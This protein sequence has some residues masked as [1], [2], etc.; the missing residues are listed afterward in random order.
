MFGYIT[1][2]KPELKIKEYEK[3]KSYYCGLCRVLR[4]EYGISGQM[5]LTYDMTFAIILLTSLYE[6]ETIKNEYRCSVHPMKKQTMLQNEITHYAA[7]MNVLL[8]YY[9]FADNWKDEKSISGLVEMKILKKKVQRIIKRYP[10]KSAVIRRSLQTLGQYEAMQTE[11]ID[12]VAGC[13]GKLMEELFT[14]RHDAWQKGLGRLGFF[15]GKFI[16]IMDAYDDLKADIK[17]GNYNPLA[18]RYE[19]E[20]YEEDCRQMLLMMMAEC[21]SEFEKLPCLQDA[22]ILRNILYMGV[23][24]R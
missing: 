9:H 1:I 21:S 11:D 16:Y 15:L 8:A 4:E 6:S 24:G 5:T 10:E 14:Y 22:D 17:K 19:Q 3:Y 18:K 12:A 23:W 2:Y 20:Q 13:F 7:D